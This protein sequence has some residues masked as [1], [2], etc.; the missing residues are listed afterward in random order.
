M[1]EIVFIVMASFTSY[2]SQRNLVELIDN[3]F[4]LRINLGTAGSEWVNLIDAHAFIKPKIVSFDFFL[5]LGQIFGIYNSNNLAYNLEE[6]S[7]L[8]AEDLLNNQ[9]D[10]FTACKLQNKYQALSL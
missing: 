2:S 4:S 6:N 3:G 5:K 8:L 10:R 1:R 7:I 9:W